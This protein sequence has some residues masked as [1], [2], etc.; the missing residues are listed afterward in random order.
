MCYH[1]CM[2]NMR[3]YSKGGIQSTPRQTAYARRIWAGAGNSKKEIA[4]DV[5]YA[6][7][8]ANVAVDHIEKT[9]GFHN[10]M[11]KLAA[12]SNGVA[13]SILHEFRVRGVQDF[14]NKDLIGALNAIGSAW[15]KFNAPLLKNMDGPGTKAG[16][17]RLR[18]VILQQVENQ[19]INAPPPVL[20]SEEQLDF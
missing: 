20:P 12:E 7:S 18:T 9:K 19:V 13:L 16:N 17:N 8:T 11:A 14:S 10:A 4:I 6:P 15:G 5:G 1:T 3:P 2:T